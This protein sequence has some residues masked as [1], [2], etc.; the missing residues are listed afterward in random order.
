MEIDKTHVLDWS[1]VA[2]RERAQAGV[3]CDTQR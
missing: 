2:E 3:G 1:G